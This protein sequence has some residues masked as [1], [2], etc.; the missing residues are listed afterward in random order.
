[1]KTAIWLSYDLGVRGDYESLYAWLD[2]HQAAECGDS[3]AFLNYHHTG[4][5][6]SAVKSEIKKSLDITRNVRIYLIHRDSETK[7][8]KGTF[9]F[10]GRKAAPW[11]G[12]GS[13]G[14]N[15]VDVEES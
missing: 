14:G 5:V 2:D 9:L 12:F 6:V 4:P 7:K 11:S 3:V 13:R 15:V 10:G 1:M 8:I